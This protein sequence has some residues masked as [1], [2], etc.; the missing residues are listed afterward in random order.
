VTKYPPLFGVGKKIVEPV[1]IC[2][3]GFSQLGS[4]DRKWHLASQSTPLCHG[5][6]L[7]PQSLGLVILY[8]WKII[9]FKNER[10]PT[11][12][13]IVSILTC[14]QIQSYFHG[15]SIQ[16]MLA[17][18]TS[19]SENGSTMR[20]RETVTIQENANPSHIC[21]MINN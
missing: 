19:T 12:T 14:D 9:S 3:I 6:V 11:L 20:I 10:L 18:V 5:F 1:Q 7:G 21:V 17:K 15:D 8:I 16:V 2:L 4:S 13:N